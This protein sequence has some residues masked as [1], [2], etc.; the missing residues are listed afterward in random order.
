MTAK[1]FLHE[2]DPMQARIDFLQEE[3]DRRRE[4]LSLVPGIDYTKI[5]VQ[6]SAWESRIEEETTR[7]ADKERE[8]DELLANYVSCRIK[9]LGTL[10][11]LKNSDQTQ[12]LIKHY[13]ERKPWK[14]VIDEMG[15]S[16]TAIYRKKRL[17]I[18]ALQEIL[19]KA[20]LPL[21]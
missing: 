15:Q 9:K 14:I 11:M 6:S 13:I 16:D 21:G 2:L 5:K 12:I 1:E 20:E 10:F 19:D 18:E 4:Q 17:A 7:I 3:I 8:L